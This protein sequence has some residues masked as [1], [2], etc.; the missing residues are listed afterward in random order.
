MTQRLVKIAAL[1]GALAFASASF[2][3]STSM[4]AQPDPSRGAEA[5]TM[6]PSGAVNPPQRPDNSSPNS[7][8]AVR[9]EARAENRNNAN[10]LVPKGEA[11]TTTAGRPNAPAP[12]GAMTRAEVRPTPGELKPQMGQRGERPDV[13]TNPKNAT[14]TPK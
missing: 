11:S 5:S 2:A 1:S 4:P 6:T 9:S 10:S 3:Q 14:G 12:T 13:P 8:A 7:R